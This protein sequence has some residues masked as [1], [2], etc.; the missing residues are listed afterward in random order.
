VTLDSQERIEEIQWDRRD[1]NGSLLTSAPFIRDVQIRIDGWGGRLYQAD[2][3]PDTTTHVPFDP[4]PWTNVSSIQMVYNDDL[5]N[6]YVS[7]WNRGMQPLQILTGTNLPVARVNSSYQTL[8]VAAGGHSPYTWSLQGGNLPQGLNLGGTG[9]LLGNPT[10][11]GLYNFTVRVTDSNQQSLEQS[12]TLE[13]RAAAGVVRV[14]SKM[15]NPGQFELTVAAQAGQTY[16]IQYSS[17]LRNWFPLITTNAPA[18]S[19]DVLDATASE[20]ARFYRV[21]QP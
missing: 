5:G 8:F 9:E 6:Q 11:V 10:Q 17:D 20:N 18:D 12:F 1:V 7:F 16:T 21:L 2:V 15:R 4:V 14:Q 13:V 3:S 19:F